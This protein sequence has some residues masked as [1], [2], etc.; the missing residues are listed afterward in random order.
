MPPAGFEPAIPASEWPQAQAFDHAI[1]GI[2][3]FDIRT[4][5]QVTEDFSHVNCGFIITTVQFSKVELNATMNTEQIKA[6]R[7]K[8][9]VNHLTDKK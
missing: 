8:A 3:R 5:Q 4:V 6:K 9:S 7:F 1:T 2:G